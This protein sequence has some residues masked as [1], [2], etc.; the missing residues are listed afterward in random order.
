MKKKIKGTNYLVDEYGNVYSPRGFKL[1][2]RVCIGGYDRVILFIDGK[3]KDR[4][5]SRLVAEAF[6]PNKRNKIVFCQVAHKNGNK[7]ENTKWNVIWVSAEENGQ[8]RRK[9]EQEVID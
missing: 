6:V 3:R 1:K 9:F 5:V 2:S 7:R 8:L 4:K